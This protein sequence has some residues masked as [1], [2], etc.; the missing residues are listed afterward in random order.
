MKRITALA[1][2]ICFLFT[3]ALS[4]FQVKTLAADS[5]KQQ[6]SYIEVVPAAAGIDYEALY[7]S[8]PAEELVASVNGEPVLWDEY[9]YFYCGYAAEVE[10]IMDYYGQNGVPISWEDTYQDGMTWADVPA[11]SAEQSICEY[12][13]IHLFAEEN[14]ISLPADAEEQIDRQI[15]ESA[16]SVL[17]E[18]ATEEA[19]AAYLAKGYLSMPVYRRMLSTNLLYQQLLTELYDGETEEGDVQNA[20]ADL[21]EKLQQNL[22]K[23]SFVP[24]GSFQRPNVMSY[25]IGG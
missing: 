18:G 7:R 2:V 3:G 21:T 1:A 19:F 11:E 16:E 14:G 13:G 10:S 24:E 17:G 15:I 22:E 5:A 25:Q 20:Q 23:I 9:F 4:V 6:E 12:R 8:H